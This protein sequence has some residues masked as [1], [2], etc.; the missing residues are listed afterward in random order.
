MQIF[1]FNYSLFR[2]AAFH[3]YG[4]VLRQGRIVSENTSA[5]R[6]E[7]K[8]YPFLSSK[9]I[10]F[11]QTS[12]TELIHSL[13]IIEC[14]SVFIQYVFGI[15]LTIFAF[16]IELIVSRYV[17]KQNLKKDVCLGSCVRP[18]AP[19]KGRCQFHHYRHFQYHRN[20]RKT[21]NKRINRIEINKLVQVDVQMPTAVRIIF[22]IN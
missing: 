4:F 1:T 20:H 2:I 13:N 18:K 12:G 8:R 22:E 11:E 17:P 16:V 7:S 6:L 19:I 15:V 9:A 21:S 10:F 5:F 3:E 14:R